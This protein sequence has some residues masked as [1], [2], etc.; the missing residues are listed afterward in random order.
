[1]SLSDPRFK[2]TTR[3][4]KRGKYEMAKNAGPVCQFNVP[5]YEILV[6]IIIVSSTSNLQ[7]ES[8]SH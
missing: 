6:I 3:A 2:E 5:R 7:L 4:A 1:M 8:Q